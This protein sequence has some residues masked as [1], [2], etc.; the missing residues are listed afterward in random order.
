MAETNTNT[1]KTNSGAKV[2]GVCYNPGGK[3]PEF[4]GFNYTCDEVIKSIY[5]SAKHELGDGISEKDIVGLVIVNRDNYQYD[6]DT[7]Q[8]VP[9]RAISFQIAMDAN[10]SAI[11][12]DF[13]AMLNTYV[14]EFSEGYR[15]FARKYCNVKDDKFEKP[16]GT[17]SVNGKKIKVLFLDTNKVFMELVDGYNRVYSEKY[18]GDRNQTYR[19]DV[20]AVY[21]PEFVDKNGNITL[22]R[23]T[24]IEKA[25][26][27]FVVT[28][29]LMKAGTNGFSGVYSTKKITV[30]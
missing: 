11:S 4:A 9:A 3:E 14:T 18:G 16:L 24:S 25:I 1:T 26:D 5:K 23:S 21:K 7:K 29:T 12:G 27:H 22:N 30:K 13:N 28:K 6:A 17:S 2:P 15:T 8:N 20:E 19:I 10:N